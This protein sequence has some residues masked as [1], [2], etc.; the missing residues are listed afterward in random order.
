MS[1]I[2]QPVFVNTFNVENKVQILDSGANYSV[3]ST[4]AHKD[5]DSKIELS[6]TLETIDTAGSQS[7]NI[8][9]MVE[10]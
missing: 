8:K 7:T 10:W 6:D 1:K 5:I 9:V 2:P 4:V 3:L